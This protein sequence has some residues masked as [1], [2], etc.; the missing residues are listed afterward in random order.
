MQ[1]VFKEHYIIDGDTFKVVFLLA[2]GAKLDAGMMPYHILEVQKLPDP[3]KYHFNKGEVG[4]SGANGIVPAENER[5]ITWNDSTQRQ[6]IN[7][8]KNQKIP[9]IF[10]INPNLTR[11]FF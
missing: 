10:F 7:M 5:S 6:L 3:T 4:F 8:I 1:E 2:P 11:A 9:A